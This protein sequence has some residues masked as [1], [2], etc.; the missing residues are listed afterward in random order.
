MHRFPSG[1]DNL[2]EELR[3]TLWLE[4][5]KGAAMPGSHAAE[6]VVDFLESSQDW[7]EVV[8]AED[9]TEPELDL[10][11]LPPPRPSVR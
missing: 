11:P 1:A 6:I 10:P 8:L 9:E 7:P 4:R 5:L 2:R 3:Q